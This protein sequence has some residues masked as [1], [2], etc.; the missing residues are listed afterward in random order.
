MVSQL[1][2][3]LVG[4]KYNISDKLPKDEIRDVSLYGNKMLETDIQGG[5]ILKD[6]KFK[7]YKSDVITKRVIK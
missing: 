5:K 6:V 4:I 7:C 1:K 2:N 3:Y